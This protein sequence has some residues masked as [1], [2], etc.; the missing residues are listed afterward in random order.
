MKV[1]AI[2]GVII[3][4]TL[5][6]SLSLTAMAGKPTP[7]VTVGSITYEVNYDGQGHDRVVAQNVSWQKVHP[8]MILVGLSGN[9]T[10][11][12]N[13]MTL[14]PKGKAAKYPQ[15]ITCDVVTSSTRFLTGEA[16]EVTIH[17]LRGNWF[18]LY[19]TDVLTTLSWG[20]NSTWTPT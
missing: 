3:A 19:L 9:I 7:Q 4:L 15:D 12:I 14:A 20:T 2:L 16:V 10:P 17:M 5:V 6:F 13:G 8:A 18:S 1:K 11:G